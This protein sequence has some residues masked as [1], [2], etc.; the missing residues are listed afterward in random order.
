MV[1][2]RSDKSEET[3]MTSVSSYATV[4]LFLWIIIRD[5]QFIQWIKFTT[6]LKILNY[7]D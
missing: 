6:I 4:R 1:K 7:I 3:K 2:D 5:L